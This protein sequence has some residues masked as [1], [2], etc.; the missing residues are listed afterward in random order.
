MSWKSCLTVQELKS[1]VTVTLMKHKVT[2]SHGE[3]PRI[4]TGLKHIGMCA[5]QS[6]K[7]QNLA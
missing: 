7:P 6:I 3:L 1:E 2:D 4:S 5:V